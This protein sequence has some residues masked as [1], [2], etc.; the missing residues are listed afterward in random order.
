MS[1]S[2]PSQNQHLQNQHLPGT[3]TTQRND[4]IDPF[5]KHHLSLTELPRTNSYSLPTR[6]GYC[7]VQQ[8]HQRPLSIRFS[9]G[10]CS[11]LSSPLADSGLDPTRVSS[12]ISSPLTSLPPLIPLEV[13]LAS[14]HIYIPPPCL[15]FRSPS[16][17]SRR[18]STLAIV[19]PAFVTRRS[20]AVL[21]T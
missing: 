19:S 9:I 2:S 10:F 7:E 15:V 16:T 8:S 6:K 3:N 5:F 18:A 11:T 21:P 12:Y 13:V 4:S 1:S 20:P 14:W 17:L